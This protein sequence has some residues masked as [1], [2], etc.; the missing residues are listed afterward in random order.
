M[1]RRNQLIGI[2]FDQNTKRSNAVWVPFCGEPAATTTGLARLAEISGAPVVPVFIVRQPDCHS[3]RIVIQ[4]EIPL[5]RGTGGQVDVEQTTGR[6]ARAI[7]EM[8]TQYPEQ[9]LWTHRRYRTRPDCSTP[10]FYD[11]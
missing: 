6:F 3:H 2:P 7:E 8:V 11:S 10:P 4:D 9:F 5:V 1:L